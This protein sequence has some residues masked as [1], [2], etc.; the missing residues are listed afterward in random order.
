MAQNCTSF[1]YHIENDICSYK[2][3]FISMNC[4]DKFNEFPGVVILRKC[5]YFLLETL[6]KLEVIVGF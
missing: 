5:G 2:P 3:F 4:T 1:E 6:W